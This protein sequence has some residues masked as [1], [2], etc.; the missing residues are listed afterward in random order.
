MKARVYSSSESLV[1]SSPRKNP[2]TL[3]LAHLYDGGKYANEAVT[4]GLTS[5]VTLTC[6]LRVE[7]LDPRRP[8]GNEFSG[9]STGWFGRLTL[10]LWEVSGARE[11]EMVKENLK[12]GVE[13]SKDLLFYSCVAEDCGVVATEEST[14]RRCGGGRLNRRATRD[15]ARRQ[16]VSFLVARI[17]LFVCLAGQKAP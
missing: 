17:S 4:V 7:S 2:R 3:N 15:I 8:K 11:A 5:S 10:D 9:H 12:R 16:C 13:I 1:R 6:V 14:L